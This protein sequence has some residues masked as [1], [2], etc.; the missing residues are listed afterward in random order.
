[1]IL[2]AL[3]YLRPLSYAWPLNRVFTNHIWMVARRV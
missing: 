2:D 1:M 3:R